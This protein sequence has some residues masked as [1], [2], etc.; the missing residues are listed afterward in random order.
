[1]KRMVNF[2]APRSGANHL[3]KQTQLYEGRAMPVKGKSEGN[4]ADIGKNQLNFLEG[5][6]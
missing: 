2:D 5:C 6:S 1:M 3:Q 4:V